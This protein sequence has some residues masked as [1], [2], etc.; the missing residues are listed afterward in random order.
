MGEKGLRDDPAVLKLPSGYKITSPVDGHVGT[1][2]WDGGGGPGRGIVW[3]SATGSWRP[4]GFTD[5]DPSDPG[6]ITNPTTGGEAYWDKDAGRWIDTKTGK[7]VSYE[8]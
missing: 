3:D 4:P 7:A 6:R 8:Q 1:A 2:E 5:V